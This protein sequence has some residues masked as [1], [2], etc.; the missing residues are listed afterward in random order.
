M[1][2]INK[3]L[4]ILKNINFRYEKKDDNH[5]LDIGVDDKIKGSVSINIDGNGKSDISAKIGK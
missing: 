2:I 4:S 3:I 5:S 1:E